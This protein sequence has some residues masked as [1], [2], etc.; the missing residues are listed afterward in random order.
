MPPVCLLELGC[1][2]DAYWVVTA[3]AVM[4]SCWARR[5]VFLLG[6]R[7]RLL[8]NKKTCLLVG[9]ADMSS[10][11]TR[12]HVFLF[13]KKTCLPVQQDM[14]SCPTRRRLF[15]PHKK[16]RLLA[17]QKD[18]YPCAYGH[19]MCSS[20][21]KRCGV[22]RWGHLSTVSRGFCKDASVARS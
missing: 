3:Q 13:T 4:S 5:H 19:G 17:E 22:S 9:N 7:I 10:C 18:M 16:T 1:L 20:K 14:F 6:S 2:L 21:N 8:L 11:W 12:G 15:L